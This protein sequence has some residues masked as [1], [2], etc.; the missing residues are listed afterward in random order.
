MTSIS[1]V[2]RVLSGMQPSGFMTLGNYFGA[3]KNW[4]HL[5]EG[6]A[7]GPFENLYCVVDYHAITTEY[8]P[9]ELRRRSLEMTKDVLACGIDPKRSALFL[10]SQ[11]PE[12]AELAW[13]LA[14]STS[15]GQLQRMT[16]FKDKSEGKEFVSVGLFTYPVLMAA[17]I[18]IYKATHVPVG[19]DQKQHLELA[20]DIAEKF[21]ATFGDTFPL[22][23]VVYTAATRVMSL[24]DP[25]KKMSKSAGE[26]HYVGVFEDEASFR[27]KIKSAVTATGGAPTGEMAPG[28]RNLLL[29]L[30]AAHAPKG[31]VDGFAAAD[32]DGKLKYSELKDAVTKQLLDYLAPIRER[33]AKITDEEAFAALRSGAEKARAIAS[34]TLREVREKI[35]LLEVR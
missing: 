7:K 3:V 26:D 21:N 23:E 25:T 16:Q 8:E 13:V 9:A 6:D 35:G 33:R 24:K 32:K 1:R 14:S 22:P 18:V 34:V 5:Q 31:L 19:E 10:Q 17:D 30:T 29:L 11:V 20:R 28:V 12:H 15:Y 27:K 2:R 4:V